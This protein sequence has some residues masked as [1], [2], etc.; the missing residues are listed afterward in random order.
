M[1]ISE[2]NSVQVFWPWQEEQLTKVFKSA[3]MARFK[4]EAWDVYKDGVFQ[5]TEY[6]IRA[7]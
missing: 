3:P 4:V 2:S 5:R 7:T 1:G 6:N